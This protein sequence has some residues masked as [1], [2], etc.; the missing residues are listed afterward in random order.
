MFFKSVEIRIT[1]RVESDVSKVLKVVEIL[2]M[3][4]IYL[5]KWTRTCIHKMIDDPPLIDS[6]QNNLK[7]YL[8]F[9]EV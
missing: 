7:L 8:C 5:S 1:F 9:L 4:R 3:L 6:V 2:F